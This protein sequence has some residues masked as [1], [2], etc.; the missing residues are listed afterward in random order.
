M[1]ILKKN[2]MKIAYSF[3][4]VD[5]FHIGHMR[6]FEKAKSQSDRHIFG[7]SDNASVIT[8][9][10]KQTGKVFFTIL[11]RKKRA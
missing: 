6:A 11:L 7:L 9:D 1:N 10:I 2:T 8:P 3:G 4:V 5:L